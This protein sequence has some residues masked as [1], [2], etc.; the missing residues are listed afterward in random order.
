MVYIVHEKTY[1]NYNVSDSKILG[2]YATL[3]DANNMVRTQCA[4][5]AERNDH[6]ADSSEA[7]QDDGCI[8]WE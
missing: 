2:C 5:H 1:L 4:Y 6:N 7:R 3:S 8:R